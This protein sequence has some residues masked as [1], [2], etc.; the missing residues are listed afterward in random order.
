M[1]L[2]FEDPIPKGFVFREIVEF[3]PTKDCGRTPNW[4]LNVRELY[5]SKKTSTPVVI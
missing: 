1:T 5:C 3:R 2:K 4:V